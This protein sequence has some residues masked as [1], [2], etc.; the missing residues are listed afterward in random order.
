[1]G[2]VVA[3]LDRR[4]QERRAQVP[5]LAKRAA[6]EGVAEI[7]SLE[8]LIPVLFPHTIYKSYPESFVDRGKW[9]QMN[10]WLD[11]LSAR[12]VDIDVDGVEDV[13]GWIDRL[14]S[15][16]HFVSVSSGTTGKSSF[17]NKSQGDRDATTQNQLDALGEVG[18]LPDHSWH[19]V[20]LAPDTGNPSARVMHDVFLEHVARPDNIPYFTSGTVAGGQHS[21][22][23][24]MISLRR[25]IADGT[26]APSD[27]AAADEDAA[28]RRADTDALLA[29][30]ADQMLDHR[31]ERFFI[32]SYMALAWR[33]AEVLRAR[34]V[35][36]G[37]LTGANA[38]FIAGG[39]KGAD[40]PP[41]HE[42]QILAALHV[43]QGR[44]LH[45]YSM[46]ELNVGLAKCVAGRYHPAPG[47][48][49]L[50]LDEPGETM[51]P[52]SDG[53]VE[54]RAAFFDFTIDGRWGGT[55]SGDR[56]RV[57]VDTCACGRPGPTV[58]ADIVRYSNLADG[59]KITCAGAMDAYVRG[60]VGD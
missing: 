36:P 52:V 30:Y 5:L 45:R 27:V 43:D 40:L 19:F 15:A 59:D 28:R 14:A 31:D 37:D 49:L 55:I 34:G 39:T 24:R 25:A 1:M 29:H 58:A 8:D 20:P 51:A 4:F 41:D 53:Q 6:E 16:G 9:K 13:D 60:I 10:R 35:A 56:V 17:L 44:F 22:I 33:F 54:G 26:A 3:A 32:G 7:R 42:R 2:D 46:Q 18:V 38:L 48:V 47:L 21:S 50:V 11:S 57:D 23:A 12:R